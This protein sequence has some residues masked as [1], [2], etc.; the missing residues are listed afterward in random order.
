MYPC[1]IPYQ[2]FQIFNGSSRQGRKAIFSL[3]ICDWQIAHPDIRLK[4]AS[5]Q[6]E[7]TQDAY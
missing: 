2:T 7:M 6:G 1:C 4:V 5:D 3:V